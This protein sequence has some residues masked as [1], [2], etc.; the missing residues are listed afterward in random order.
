[1]TPKFGRRT[2]LS[3]SLSALL[4]AG[5]TRVEQ[6]PTPSPTP[7]PSK[8][9]TPSATPT[10]SPTPTPTATANLPEGLVNVLIAGSDSRTADLNEDGRSDVICVAQLTADRS[11]INLVSIARD[12]VATLSDGSQSKINSAY[13]FGGIGA[14]A[15]VVSPMLGNLPLHYYLE[16]GFGWFEQ[17][18]DLLQ[19]FEVQ[20]R[21]ASSSSG[22]HFAAGPLWLTGADALTYARE[23][24]GLPNG[25]LDRTERHRACLTGIVQ[26]LGDYAR[27]MPDSMVQRTTDLWARVRPSGAITVDDVI[28]MIDMVKNMT[29]D[30]VSSAML[31][32]ARFDM[33]A[34]QSVDIIDVDRAAELI[35]QLHAG[36]ISPYQTAHGLD[37]SPTGGRG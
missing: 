32:V 37:T 19:G 10:P 9:P 33:V 31:P 18:A 14:L 21:F 20:N 26:R 11:R 6:A 16:T 30:S 22:P 4:L 28:A 35:A 34:G 2:M 3:A 25:D 17:I 1:M 7:S 15:E 12:T 24:A 23:R 27:E 36:D 29:R 13:M 5:C 8:A